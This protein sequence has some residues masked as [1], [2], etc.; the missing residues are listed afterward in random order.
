VSDDKRGQ[1]ILLSDL[2]TDA[3]RAAVGGTLAA[4]EDDCSGSWPACPRGGL[5]CD[6]RL[7]ATRAVNALKLSL[8]RATGREP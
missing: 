7:R 5:I 2:D 6:C 8:G 3:A 1:M 4:I